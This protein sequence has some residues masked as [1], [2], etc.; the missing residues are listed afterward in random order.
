MYR[1]SKTNDEKTGLALLLMLTRFL[2]LHYA[3]RHGNERS[4][5]TEAEATMPRYGIT[6]IENFVEKIRFSLLLLSPRVLVERV[7]DAGGQLTITTLNAWRAGQ[8]LPSYS[9]LRQFCRAANIEP[10]DFHLDLDAFMRRICSANGISE[11]DRKVYA[12]RFH[13]QQ[14]SG[15]RFRAFEAVTSS[16]SARL[17]ERLKGTFL[18]YN[19][20]LNNLGF[21]HTSLVR[22]EK[23]EHPFI[24]ARC[25]SLQ[26]DDCRE[27]AGQLFP[28]RNNLMLILEAQGDVHEDFVSMLLCKP[29]DTGKDVSWLNGIV[30]AS[31]ED[32]IIYPAA[33]RIYMERLSEEDA[34]R[35][36]VE[37]LHRPV[38]EWCMDFLSNKISGSDGDTVLESRLLTRSSVARARAGK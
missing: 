10:V 22:F 23:V 14:N 4:A 16:D 2:P 37:L 25:L 3:E 27:Y 36:P 38:P 30:L 13:S 15:L 12:A 31:A 1:L 20:V 21:V 35:D 8:N 18:A 24:V 28:T 34:G 29:M 26:D 17:F 11:E 9:K 32:Q 5:F 33:A 7:L 19:L 6:D